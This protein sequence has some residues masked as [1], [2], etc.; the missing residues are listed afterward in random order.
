[1]TSW[2]SP[3]NANDGPRASNEDARIGNPPNPMKFA[4]LEGRSESEKTKRKWCE[5]Q[6]HKKNTHP[7]KPRLLSDNP[8]GTENQRTDQSYDKSGKD[9]FHDYLTGK[10]IPHSGRHTFLC[11][12]GCFG[13]ALMR[14]MAQRIGRTANA[15]PAG[16]GRLTVSKRFVFRHVSET[17][18]T[19]V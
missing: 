2:S 10:Q 19:V 15:P 9:V 13:L 8:R 5:E 6:N 16:L 4:W 17:R 1:M 3:A 12:I 14:P 18:K 7:A 11:V